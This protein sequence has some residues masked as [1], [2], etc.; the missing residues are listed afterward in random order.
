VSN[1]TELHPSVSPPVSTPLPPVSPTL[2]RDTLRLLDA[3]TRL[4]HSS[5]PNAILIHSFNCLPLTRVV[6]AGLTELKNNATGHEGFLWHNALG[7]AMR[8]LRSLRRTLPVDERTAR[9]FAAEP[10]DR[11]N[12][13]TS[14]RSLHEA[15]VQLI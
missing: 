11:D 12:A 2:T 8:H 9:V 14:A 6:A 15:A 7:A 10:A 4:A 3:V 5:S 1:V 13:V